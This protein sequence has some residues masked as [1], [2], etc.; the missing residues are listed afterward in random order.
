MGIRSKN[1]IQELELDPRMGLCP[2]AAF[3]LKS[4]NV[5]RIKRHIPEASEKSHTLVKLNFRGS[6]GRRRFDRGQGVWD[7]FA[8]GQTKLPPFT[9]QS[10]LA[11]V[12]HTP[13]TS[14]SDPVTWSKCN[15]CPRRYSQF[16]SPP[17]IR[18]LEKP[19]DPESF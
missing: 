11:T 8:Q 16:S 14:A 9:D 3:A 5:T 18:F 7:V 13:A 17:G 15:S 4:I 6:R 10:D 19:A 12:R 1:Y 2:V